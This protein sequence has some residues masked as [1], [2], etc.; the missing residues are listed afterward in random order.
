VA[1]PFAVA[2]PVCW[3]R[4]AGGTVIRMVLIERS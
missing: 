3:V 1:F 4:V 2:E